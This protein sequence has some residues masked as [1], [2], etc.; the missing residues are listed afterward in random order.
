MPSLTTSAGLAGAVALAF[1]LAAP[2]LAA[3]VPLDDAPPLDRPAASGLKL[4]TKKMPP[5]S[6]SD[7]A[8]P[9]AAPASPASPS[10][11]DAAPTVPAAPSTAPP[12]AADLSSPVKRTLTDCMKLW[13]KATHMSKAEWKTTCIR[14]QKEADRHERDVARERKKLEKSKKPL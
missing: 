6:G 3:P 4:A 11:S 5:R 2:A 7:Q 8:A 1:L 12:G 14:S 9:A 10:A 13:D